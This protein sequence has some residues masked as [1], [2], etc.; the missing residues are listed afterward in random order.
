MIE[1]TFRT[2]NQTAQLK[3]SPDTKTLEVFV[4]DKFSCRFPVENVWDMMI[5]VL[6]QTEAKV[7]QLG[8]LRRRKEAMMAKLSTLVDLQMEVPIEKM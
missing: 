8:R 5:N 2:K 3:L 7:S 6:T 4:E 1:L